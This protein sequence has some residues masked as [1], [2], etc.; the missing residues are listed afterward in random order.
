MTDKR[1]EQLKEAQARFRA[2]RKAEDSEVIK[3]LKE[4]LRLLKKT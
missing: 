4:I 3:L 2:K 1:K